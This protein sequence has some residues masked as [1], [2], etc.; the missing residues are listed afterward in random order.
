MEQATNQIEHMKRAPEHCNLRVG[1]GGQPTE[2]LQPFIWLNRFAYGVNIQ[3]VLSIDMLHMPL[4][5][6]G[7]YHFPI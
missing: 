3:I 4:S 7:S 2:L 6:Q 1:E 5:T